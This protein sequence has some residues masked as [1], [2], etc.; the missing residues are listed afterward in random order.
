VGSST[1]VE[2]QAVLRNALCGLIAFTLLSGSWVLVLS[3][4]Y[5]ALTITTA[6]S[7]NF[8]LVRLGYPHRR[9]LIAPPNPTALNYWEDP[10]LALQMAGGRPLRFMAPLAL[11]NQSLPWTGRPDRLWRKGL[12]TIRIIGSFSWGA[13]VVLLVGTGLSVV[14]K[15]RDRVVAY[16]VLTFWIYAGGYALIVVEPRYLWVACFMLMTIGFHWWARLNTRSASLEQ[17][18][19][20]DVLLLVFVASFWVA[21]AMGLLKPAGTE[22]ITRISGAVGRY[23]IRGNIASDTNWSDMMFMGFYRNYRY[24]GTTGHGE[25]ARDVRKELTDNDID[26]YFVWDA[27]FDLGSEYREITGGGIPEAR[28]LR[29]YSLKQPPG[30]R[31]TPSR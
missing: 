4:K 22:Y 28:G 24:F 13:L 11:Q 12:A 7:A 15:G 26:Y 31:D 17:R 16:A 19:G 30:P 6:A 14:T 21:P 9:M 23:D 3:R 20:L 27:A 1:R 8:D 18:T 2:K 25:G 29:I 10:V 5:H